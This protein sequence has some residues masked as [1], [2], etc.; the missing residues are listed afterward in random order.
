MKIA[1]NDVQ[2]KEVI[3]QYVRTLRVGGKPYIDQGYYLAVGAL[4]KEGVNWMEWT[5]SGRHNPEDIAEYVGSL[6]VG[7]PHE[8]NHLYTFSIDLESQRVY[9]LTL[10]S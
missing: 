1:E 5:Q 9:E 8:E 2:I 3:A 7:F 4:L 6:N 10:R